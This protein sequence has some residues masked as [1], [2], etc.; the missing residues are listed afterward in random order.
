MTERERSSLNTKGPKTE[1]NEQIRDVSEVKLGANLKFL[2]V[3]AEL[4][5]IDIFSQGND[6]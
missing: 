4:D 1:P 5:Q 6:S 3:M 2:E